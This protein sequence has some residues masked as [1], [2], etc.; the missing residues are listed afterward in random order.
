MTSCLLQALLL[1]FQVWFSTL[2]FGAKPDAA[3]PLSTV[4]ILLEQEVGLTPQVTLPLC[5]SLVKV[6]RK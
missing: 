5:L 1:D 6:S 2:P 3:T 4:L